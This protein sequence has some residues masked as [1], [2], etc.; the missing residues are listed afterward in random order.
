M[1]AKFNLEFSYLLKQ[2]QY[3]HLPSSATY[4]SMLAAFTKRRNGEKLDRQSEQNFVA[5]YRLVESNGVE[6]IYKGNQ[7][8]VKQ[9]EVFKLFDSAHSKLIHPGRDLMCKELKRYYG[10]T[11]QIAQLYVS[12]CEGCESKKAK[13]KKGLVV[14][15]IRSNNF[16]DRCQVD[17]IDL[18]ARPDGEYKFLMVPLTHKSA[19]EV[20]TKLIE[21]FATFGA[22]KILHSD[23]GKEFANKIVSEVVSKWPQ[24]KIVHGKPRHSQS[25][26]SVERANCDIGDIL[27]MYL[28]QEKSTAWASALHIV[29][30]AKNSRWHR[31]IKRSPYEAMFGRKMM[32]GYEDDQALEFEQTL[33]DDQTLEDESDEYVPIDGSH[34]IALAETDE[35][36]YKSNSASPSQSRSPSSERSQSPS[37]LNNTIARLQQFPQRERQMF[38]EVENEEP[39][40]SESNEPS[41]SEVINEENQLNKLHFQREAEREGARAQQKRQAQQMLEGSAK[42][43]PPIPVGQTVR[44][45]VP[46]V[47]RAKTDPRN[48]LGVVM[49]ADDGF[50]SIG[51]G[52]GILKD[53]YTRNQ[54]DPCSSQHV[55][56]ESVPDKEISLRSAVGADSLSGTQGPVHCSCFR[57]CKTG[58]CKCKSFGRLCN[59][60]C[61]NSTSCKNK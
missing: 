13:A 61:H 1:E 19:A 59:S 4:D 60:R 46:A 48:L 39:S 27:I 18:Q 52:V 32:L 33:E 30:A 11:Q 37:S 8:V 57:G 43:F 36:L 38:F 15:P 29:Q 31:G 44:V 9:E 28:R 3:I 7:E 5:R 49:A 34:W 10:I 58:K 12:L 35:P 53:K 47:D 42:R 20:A 6:K 14:K 40:F 54:I 22:P 25:Q 2:K 50:Y 45:P 55:T 17:L 24:C 21:I 56:M 26:G 51:T 23:N 16:N 41:F